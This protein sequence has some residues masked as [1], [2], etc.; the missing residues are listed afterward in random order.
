MNVDTI[1][2]KFNYEIQPELLSSWYRVQTETPKGIVKE[3]Y[4]LPLELGEHKA[5]TRVEYHPVAFNGEPL[6]LIEFSL[7]QVL[8][9]INYQPV[10]DLNEAIHQVN[11]ALAQYPFWENLDIASGNIQRLD[12]YH[13]FPAGDLTQ[14]YLFALSHMQMGRRQTIAYKEKEVIFKSKNH[15]TKFYDKYDQSGDPRTEGRL[16]YEVTLKKTIK[17]MEYLDLEEYPTLQSVNDELIQTIL[18]KDLSLLKLK[19]L[20]IPVDKTALRILTKTYGGSKAANLYGFWDIA[21]QVPKE[22]LPDLFGLSKSMINRKIRDLNKA[23]IALAKAPHQ[24]L[25]PLVMH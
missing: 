23:G 17:I 1:R 20:Q 2:L 21:F 6:L 10:G 25:P 16:R 12:V 9:G 19:D 24:D 18:E 8:Y 3:M 22:E 14:D 11:Q 15:L 7:P 13:D 4:W 5:H